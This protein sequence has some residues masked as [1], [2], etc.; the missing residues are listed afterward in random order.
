M[1]ILMFVGTI[2]FL[3]IGAVTAAFL[4]FGWIGGVLATAFLLFVTAK[5]VFF[6][7][8]LVAPLLAL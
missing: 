1:G 7:S 5:L 4:L 2:F 8:A 3:Y 6:L